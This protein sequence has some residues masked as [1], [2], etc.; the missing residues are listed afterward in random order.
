MTPSEIGAIGS[1][2]SASLYALC[3]K[4]IHMKLALS[5]STGGDGNHAAGACDFDIVARGSRFIA[6]A[7]QSHI[8]TNIAEGLIVE[9]EAGAPTLEMSSG[10]NACRTPNGN[11]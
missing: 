4:I 5:E 8:V 3:T 1:L 11:H 2:D 7:L 10:R 9:D 6:L